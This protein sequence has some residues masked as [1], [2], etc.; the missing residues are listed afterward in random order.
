MTGKKSKKPNSRAAFDDDEDSISVTS[1]QPSEHSEDSVFEVDRILAER[2]QNG[3]AEYLIR[4]AD[5]PEERSS[6][7]PKDQFRDQDPLDDWMTRKVREKKGLER[8]FNVAKFEG[9]SQFIGRRTCR[10]TTTT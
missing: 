6:W 10:T 1:T 4:W 8:P 9:S 2:T 7:E 3:R 5:Y